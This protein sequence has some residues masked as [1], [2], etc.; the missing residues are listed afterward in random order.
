MMRLSTRRK[1]PVSLPVLLPP[2]DRFGGA[3]CL[4][5]RLR[6]WIR[7]ERVRARAGCTLSGLER[8][9]AGTLSNAKF[10]ARAA[11]YDAMLDLVEEQAQWA[12]NEARRL[13]KAA[14]GG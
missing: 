11:V 1:C 5:V 4:K 12:L 8:W 2:L 10:T 13:K 3:A 14:R 6:W 9:E 7:P